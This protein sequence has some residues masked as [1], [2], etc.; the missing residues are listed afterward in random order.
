MRNPTY[1]QALTQQGVQWTYVEQ[2][3]LIEINAGKGLKNQAR[4]DCPLEDELVE[5][6]TLAYKNRSEFPPLVLHKPGRGQYVPIDG[7][8]L[9][10]SAGKAGRRWHDAYVVDT[11]DQ[12]VV[13]R[14][15]WVFNN[16]VNGKRLSREDCLQHAITFVRKYG[17][18]CRA[19]AKEWGLHES[20]VNKAVRAINTRERLEE[21]GVRVP[22]SAPQDIIIRLG[23]ITQAGDVVLKAA[24]EAVFRSGVAAKEVDQLGARRAPGEE[25]KEVRAVAREVVEKLVTLYG[26]GALP[27]EEAS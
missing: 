7:N 4:L 3:P 22:Q 2:V 14:L 25:G 26:L 1:E 9:L 5:T 11:P 23:E 21:V 12:M 13:D 8:H 17:H 20:L 16:L 6:Y 10:E 24:A 27:R 19:A 15:T 18:T